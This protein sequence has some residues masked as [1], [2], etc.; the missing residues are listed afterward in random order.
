[1][2]SSRETLRVPLLEGEL[3]IFS[4]CPL[5][6]SEREERDIFLFLFYF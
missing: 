6:K 3:F 4:F 2:R 1:M 5:L